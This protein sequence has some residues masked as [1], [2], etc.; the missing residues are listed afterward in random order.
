LVQI[1]GQDLDVRAPSVSEGSPGVRPGGAKFAEELQ[2]ANGQR[3]DLLAGGA[4]GHPEADGRIGRA[5][6]Y[7]L[8][9][10]FLLE[11][12]EGVR[13]AKELGDADEEIAVKA[14]HLGGILAQKLEVIG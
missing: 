1:G 12:L 5:L 6:V 9:K 7:Q 3:V 2:E 14:L 4:A 8:G 11:S 10:D 13:I